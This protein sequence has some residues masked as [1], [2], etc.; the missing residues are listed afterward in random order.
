KYC[1]GN[2]FRGNRKAE[3][4]N[5]I[6]LEPGVPLEM[7]VILGE[8]P[9]G[10]FSAMLVVEEEGVEYERNRQGG[11][12][13]PMFTTA[14][15]ASDL[16]DEILKHLVEGEAGISNCPVFCDYKTGSNALAG[17]AGESTPP[18]T[19]A[20]SD[21]DADTKMRT[22]VGLGGDILEAGY[23]TTVGGKVV[24][25]TAKG[26]QKKVPLAELSAADQAYVELLNPPKFNID[27]SKQSSQR[28]PDPGPYNNDAAIRV[29]DYVFGAKLKQTSSGSYNHGL[30]IEFFAIGAETG[31]DRY[32][33]LDR[34][35]STFIPTKENER[36]HSFRGKSVELLDYVTDSQRR[37]E[38]YSGFL[39]TVTDERGII[40]AYN[41]S[42]D[43]FFENLENLKRL[44]VGRY[45]DK[46][47]SRVHPTSPK[48]NRY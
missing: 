24:L 32:I 28:I 5:W 38:K 43:W 17:N 27:F 16:I 11:P 14:E 12:I 18:D 37:G 10:E 25:E 1:M 44:P 35:E 23:L 13:L 33:L 31:G 20:T 30:R 48:S 42:N 6:T 47:C 41:A 2:S 21:D 46:T 15:P 7:E 36:S 29:L 19:P 22:W 34:Q 45:M 4:G 40:I 8:V 39:I 26:R 9:G 3:V